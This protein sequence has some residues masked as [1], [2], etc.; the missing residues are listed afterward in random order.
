MFRSNDL[1][2]SRSLYINA[3]FT[4][5]ILREFLLIKELKSKLALMNAIKNDI[6]LLYKL[7]ISGVN[8]KLKFLV[9]IG[10]LIENTNPRFISTSDLGL[11]KSQANELQNEI[12]K[13]SID[14]QNNYLQRWI[15]GI[16]FN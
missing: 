9:D 16:G 4:Y 5:A 10:Y 15:F 2:R 6:N 11:K 7:K 13:L 12:A 8:K 1:K 3:V 14:I